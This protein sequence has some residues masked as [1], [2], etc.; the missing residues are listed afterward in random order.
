MTD[1]GLVEAE[2]PHPHNR[3]GA[4]GAIKERHQST[5]V[6]EVP[7]DVLSVVQE[8]ED[9]GTD[10][11]PEDS[12]PEATAPP[13]LLAGSRQPLGLPAELQSDIHQ[14]QVRDFAEQFFREQR[15]G[16]MF[17]R[18]RV[19]AD[20]LV[21]WQTEP[22]KQPLLQ[23]T[24]RSFSKAA[25][26]CFRD[27]LTYSGADLESIEIG[28]P[29]VALRVANL[30]IVCPELRDEIFSQ[31]L[32]QTNDNPVPS[33]LRRT[34]ELFLISASL[35]PS[36]KSSEIWIKAHCA[37]NTNHTD[38]RVC[39]LAQLTY[40]RFNVQ[41]VQGATQTSEV[42]T[43]DITR[44]IQ[45][46]DTGTATF[47]ASLYEQMWNQRDSHASCPVPFT[48]HMIAETL[49]AA[50]AEAHEGVF[51]L[52]GRLAR[53]DEV[54]E[55]INMGEVALDGLSIDDLASL[56][57]LWFRKLPEKLLTEK[58]AVQL[59]LGAMRTKDYVAFV[60]SLPRL[61][62]S[63]LM[64]LIGVLQRFVKAQETTKMTARNLAICFAPNIVQLSATF[65]PFAMQKQN[66]II[67]DLI[68]AL[69]EKLDTSAIYP[70]KPHEL[71]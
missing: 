36:S 30:G 61:H 60:A 33:M 69:V 46:L 64:Y 50:G 67:V 3:P 24:N 26:D 6:I 5:I 45:S 1:E 51:R 37:R 71:A 68:V 59:C 55:L 31:L 42:T 9:G 47:G 65:D 56:M 10:D 25:T 53:V 23:S 4:G 17:Q 15:A 70:L 49:F 32:K 29:A 14:F 44:I 7:E 40:I 27:I 13:R 16:R 11:V 57:K 22:L 12:A 8:A 35:F 52:A 34:W 66:D 2:R 62:Q 58:E 19:S 20:L 21:C 38:V 41:C 28:A 43:E 48:L 18:R 54:A 39:D 63:V